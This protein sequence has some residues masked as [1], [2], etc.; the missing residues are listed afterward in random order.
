MKVSRKNAEGYMDLTVYKALGN[1][2]YE[3]KRNKYKPKAKAKKAIPPNRA[4]QSN[5][6]M[7]DL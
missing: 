6:I 7:E 4:E 3:E 2:E 1:I 5:N